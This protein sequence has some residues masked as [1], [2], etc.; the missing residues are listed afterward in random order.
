MFERFQRTDPC[1]CFSRLQ[2]KTWQDIVYTVVFQMHFKQLVPQLRFKRWKSPSQLLW[3]VVLVA[4]SL[5]R[6]YR[7]LQLQYIHS[8]SCQYHVYIIQYQNIIWRLGSSMAGDDWGWLRLAK[9]FEMVWSVGR[10]AAKP[11]QV[12]NMLQLA[13]RRSSAMPRAWMISAQVDS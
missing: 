10:V 1:L 6:H 4:K 7:P 8:I 2:G 3:L 11:V 9:G 5:C 13:A 12:T